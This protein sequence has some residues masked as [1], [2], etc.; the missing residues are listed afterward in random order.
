V[1]IDLF[2]LSKRKM[3]LQKCASDVVKWLVNGFLTHYNLQEKPRFIAAFSFYWSER[4]EDR[5]IF[6]F[7][8]RLGNIGCFNAS[9]CLKNPGSEMGI[10]PQQVPNWGHFSASL[11]CFCRFSGGN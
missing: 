11:K 4:W 10:Q 6:G 1:A 2:S 5:A 7:L 8:K 3:I 9:N